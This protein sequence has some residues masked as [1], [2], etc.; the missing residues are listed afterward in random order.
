[1]S[2]V[3]VTSSPSPSKRTAARGAAIETDATAITSP[4]RRMPSFIDD[5]DA[6]DTRDRLAVPSHS[7]KATQRRVAA[8]N[9][10]G[11]GLNTVAHKRAGSPATTSP[12]RKRSTP[13]RV[14]E[15]TELRSQSLHAPSWTMRLQA[16]RLLLARHRSRQ[17]RAAWW[18][19]L[20]RLGEQLVL[21]QGSECARTLLDLLVEYR[22]Q[23]TKDATNDANDVNDVNYT[24]PS[25]IIPVSC[26]NVHL[27]KLQVQALVRTLHV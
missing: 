25:S 23:W 11:G 21:R 6:P 19:D 9:D 14:D 10:R 4:L 15:E 3:P 1:M 20:Y 27:D 7:P 16:M 17:N 13:L 2:P 18:R 24:T 12:V 22:D 26:G 8:E 5:E